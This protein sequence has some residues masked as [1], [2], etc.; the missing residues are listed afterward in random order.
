MKKFS[1]F[2][3]YSYL[4]T[5]AYFKSRPN[6]RV[7]IVFYVEAIDANDVYI[8]KLGDF[9]SESSHIHMSTIRITETRD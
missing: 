1:V 9:T 5:S 6:A 8:N 3:E 7:T 2:L 4:P